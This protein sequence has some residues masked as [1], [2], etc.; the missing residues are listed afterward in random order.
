MEKQEQV[1]CIGCQQLKNDCMPNDDDQPVCFACAYPEAPKSIPSQS[2]HHAEYRE[3]SQ[4]SS[5][6]WQAEFTS[7][8]DRYPSRY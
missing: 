6:G 7:L 2:V 8:D 5:S 3:D 4:Y 1:Q